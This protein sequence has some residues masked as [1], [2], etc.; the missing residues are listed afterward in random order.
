MDLN[1]RRHELSDAHSLA[2]VM[3]PS[4][5]LSTMFNICETAP[6]LSEVGIGSCL[7]L[8]VDS[9]KDGDM[10]GSLGKLNWS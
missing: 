9:M 1:Q 4:Q 7:L 3:S 2:T 6:V 8:D 10:L 5:R